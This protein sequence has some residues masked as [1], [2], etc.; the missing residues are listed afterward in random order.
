MADDDHGLDL[1]RLRAAAD[2]GF[3]D[4]RE[5]RYREISEDELEAYIADLGRQASTRVRSTNRSD[6]Y[7]GMALANTERHLA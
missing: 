7:A 2:I 3:K 4:I 5:G 6:M 1:R